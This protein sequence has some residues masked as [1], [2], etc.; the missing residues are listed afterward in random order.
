MASRQQQ[1]GMICDEET[2]RICIVV[3]GAAALSWSGDG[4]RELDQPLEN[5]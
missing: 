1:S 5:R 2:E 3:A 4:R